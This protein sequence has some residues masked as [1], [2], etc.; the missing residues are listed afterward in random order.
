M[1]FS[2]KYNPLCHILL[3]LVALRSFLGK[4]AWMLPAGKGLARLI[5]VRAQVKFAGWALSHLG[6][7]ITMC[8]F[9]GA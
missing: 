2:T 1:G 5:I 7:D 9:N 8:H 3:Y 6:T 4:E